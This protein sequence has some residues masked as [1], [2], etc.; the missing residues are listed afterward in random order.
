M[1]I[2]YFLGTQ[3]LIQTVAG[4]RSNPRSARVVNPFRAN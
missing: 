4:K 3:S 2:A 1:Q